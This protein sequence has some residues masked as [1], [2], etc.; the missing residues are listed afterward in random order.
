M[1]RVLGRTRDPGRTGDAG[2]TTGAGQTSDARRNAGTVTDGVA[3]E[4]CGDHP[5]CD[6]QR[7]VV[8]WKTRLELRQNL[9]RTGYSPETV[10]KL[11]FAYMESF[12]D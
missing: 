5:P 3:S 10:D 12:D 11:V 4:V 7:K 2:Q 8:K 1:S 9:K 6:R